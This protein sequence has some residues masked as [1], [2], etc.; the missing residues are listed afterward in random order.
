VTPYW[1]RV[2]G[3]IAVGATKTPAP[4]SPNAFIRALSSNSPTTAGRMP[5][6]WNQSSSCRRTTVPSP[7]RSIGAPV[8]EAGN[9]RRSR[10]A[11]AG[12]A[13]QVTPLSPSRWL[14]A[15]TRTVGGTG[16]SASTRSTSWTASA[17]RSD[18]VPASRQT[19]RIDC[20]S[21]S[22]GASSR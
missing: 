16:V 8:N 1:R 15:F 18:S 3:A 11:S 13:K 19:M 4:F 22:A 20:G 6:A 10:A 5:V 12:T 17:A 14:Y 9:R 21:R 7:G 2:S